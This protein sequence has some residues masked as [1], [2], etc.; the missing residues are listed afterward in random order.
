MTRSRTE[1]QS[2]INQNLN[3]IQE[4]ILIKQINC[5]T[6]RD[7]FPISRI[8]KNFA[9]KIIGHEMKKNWISDFCKQYSSKLKSLYLYNIE[10]LYIKGKFGPI[11]KLFYNLVEYFFVLLYY[12]SRE[13]ITNIYF[14]LVTISYRRE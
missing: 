6:N 9:E 14:T 7:I 8:V 12:T 5:L 3:N 1:F 11:Y 4:Y 13:I 10:N 2:E